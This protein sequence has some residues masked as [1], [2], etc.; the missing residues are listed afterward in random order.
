VNDTLVPS[1]APLV[2]WLAKETSM[3][4]L[5][6][7]Q[8]KHIQDGEPVRVRENGQEYVLLRSDV[9]DRLAQEQVDSGPWEPEEMDRLREEAVDLLDRYGKNA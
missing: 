7:E 3:I 4:D 9:Y 1:I 5:T 2:R 8:R 6:E